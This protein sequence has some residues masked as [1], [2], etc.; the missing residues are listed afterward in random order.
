MV[1][2]TRPAILSLANQAKSFGYVDRASRALVRTTVM[3]CFVSIACVGMPVGLL[4]Q[5][6]TANTAPTGDDQT[7]NVWAL[8]GVNAAIDSRWQAILLFG[9]LGG[10][11]SRV[12]VTDLTFAPREAFRLLVGH[13]YVDPAASGST[14]IYV[15]RAG[16]LWR[17]VRRRLELENRALI[18]RRSG[19]G[20]PARL[21]DRVM[22][23]WRIDRPLRLRAFGSVE[24]FATTDSLNARRY[25][26]GAA[27][28]AGPATIE[29][30]WT[31]HRSHGRATFNAIGLT[32]F[33]RIG[34]G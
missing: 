13:V 15:L 23:S 1:V 19:Q 14:D 26:V 2:E 18:D 3:V 21:R 6:T 32:A 25:H 9:Y 12:L 10:F 24:L 8:A 27:R 7:V 5:E 22:V 17:P 34:A 28:S 30:Y 29:V 11:E 16:C 20:R 31:Q 4:A 33:W